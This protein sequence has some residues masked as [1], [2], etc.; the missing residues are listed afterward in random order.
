MWIYYL[1]IWGGHCFARDGNQCCSNV[2]IGIQLRGI[3]CISTGVFFFY[4][5]IPF[6]MFLLFCVGFF[7]LFYFWGVFIL[8]SNFVLNN[9][10]THTHIIQDKVYTHTHTH[11]IQDK[12]K[13]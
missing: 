7:G 13:I 9:T 3:I 2:L 5:S 11:V 6:L 12:V 4:A 8:H 10:Q 1:R